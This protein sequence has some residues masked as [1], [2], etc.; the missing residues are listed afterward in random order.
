MISLQHISKTFQS[1]TNS[2]HALHDVTLKINEGKI[3]GIIGFSGAGK[4]TLVRCINLLERPTEGTVTVDGQDLTALSSKELRQARQKIGMIF[5]H[6]NLMRSRTVY[7]NIAFPLKKTKLSKSE[8]EKKIL[9]LLELV[10][11]ADKKDSYPS[12]LSGGQ[13][14]RV[15]I[16][17][18]LANDPKVLLCDEATSALD[19]Q[20]TQSILALLK[21]VNQ[22]LGITIVLITH[23]MAVVK[24][25]CDRVAIM[26]LGKIVEEGSAEDIFVHPQQPLTQ[27]FI[28]TADNMDKIFELIQND[29]E[30]THIKDGEKLVRL[31]YIGDNT[32]ESLIS[33]LAETFHVTANIVYGNID[34]IKGN[35]IGKL[36]VILHG[37]E[38][39]MVKALDYIKERNVELEVIKE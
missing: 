34:I 37:E 25:I 18:A 32:T 7:Q 9:S 2:V 22:E 30:I 15:A 35:S 14:Q 4:S 17:R 1:K 38:S 20:T 36:M 31:T 27:S 3:F 16:A 12:Q 10:G 26:E 23:E 39:D 33:H 28:N 19:P 8:Q 13:K 21:K 29:N 5:Q 6:F 24:S 11:L